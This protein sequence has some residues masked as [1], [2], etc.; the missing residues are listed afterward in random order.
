[1]PAKKLA[2]KSDAGACRSRG[3]AR[4]EARF[5]AA[6]PMTEMPT[7]Y[8]DMLA[9]IK[10]RIQSQR[11][12]VVISANA[13]MVVMYWDIGRMILKRQAAAGW[14]TK[15]IDRLSLD[16]RT[17]YPGMEALSA[18]NLLS[19][20]AFAATY[21]DPAVV[22]QLVSLLPW[23]HVVRLLQKVKDAKLAFLLPAVGARARRR[24]AG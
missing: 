23:G 17:T 19:M 6:A 12:R 15:V 2:A 3:R 1:M 20:R 16:L 21:A 10:Q 18:R 9:E 7:D 22:K 14:G 4:V 13:A 5:P 8:L 11:L 24:I